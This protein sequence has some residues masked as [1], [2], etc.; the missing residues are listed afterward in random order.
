MTDRYAVIGNPVEHSKSPL[1]HAAFARQASQDIEYGKVLAP[2]DV[3]DGFSQKVDQLVA[4][5]YKGAN[6]TVPFKFQAF[7]KADALS[8]RAKMARAVNTLSFRNGNIFGDNT[9]GVGLVADIT[10]N[11]GFVIAGKRVLLA[12]AGGAGWGV[13]L[14]LLQQN[15]SLLVIGGRDIAKAEELSEA[16]RNLLGS[17]EAAKN[18]NTV[19]YARKFTEL[20]GQKFDLVINST[21]SGLSNAYPDGLPED[22]FADGALAYDMMYGRETPF[23]RIAREQGAQV[24]DG[25]GMLVEQAAEAFFIWR[26]VRPD[27]AP[28]LELMRRS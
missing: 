13:L 14:P 20:A 22:I 17:V 19:F 21:S 1:I 11:L 7:G 27:T 25:L 4:E 2:V 15:P 24:A 5:G 3:P 26:G 6:V 23:M 18:I 28:V 12:G 9:D 10:Q 16:A 8:D